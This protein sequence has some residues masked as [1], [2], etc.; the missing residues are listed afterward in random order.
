MDV[1]DLDDVQHGIEHTIRDLGQLDVLVN[2]AGVLVAKSVLDTTPD[3][4]DLV[5]R[6]S[7]RYVFFAI[8]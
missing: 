5:Y 2:N 1:Q 6:G 4:L 3:E 8:R 7:L